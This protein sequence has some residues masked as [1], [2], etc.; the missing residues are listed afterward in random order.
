MPLWGVSHSETVA[1]DFGDRITFEIVGELPAK[2]AT[3]HSGIKPEE[4]EL[5]TGGTYEVLDIL[6]TAEGGLR[7]RLRFV[8]VATA[9]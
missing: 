8:E 7:A 5:I 3:Q 4:A 1:A 6:A 2:I 9:I